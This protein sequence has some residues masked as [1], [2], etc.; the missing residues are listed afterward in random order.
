MEILETI[1]IGIAVTGILCPVLLMLALCSVSYTQV[2]E[3]L[4]QW[5]NQMGRQVSRK[6][7][8]SRFA[9][10]R[11]DRIQDYLEH[12]GVTYM[13]PG[14]A[15]PVSYLAVKGVFALL[16]MAAGL[17][18]HPAIGLLL[19]PVGFQAP[20]GLIRLSNQQDN[21]EMLADIKN[22]YDTLRIQT[23]AGVYLTHSLSECY[24]AVENGR[25]KAAL[26]TLTNRIVAKSD[27]T[28]ALEEFHEKFENK[29]IDILC[30]ILQQSLESGRTVQILEDVSSQLT[31]MQHAIHMKEK[32][33]LDRKIQVL[34]LLIFVG[35]MG[36]C[37]LG[38]GT[39]IMDSIIQF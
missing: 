2:G 1:R 21:D 8:T 32:E 22:V 3:R 17:Q 11:Y 12:Y 19:L 35:I 36:V 5:R 6:M 13:F 28:Q 27:I 38:L 16:C 9:Y 31:D 20:D 4:I 7:K 15:D 10:F 14:K 25:L 26:L 29:Y 24:L 18:I 34:Q 33:K 23:K 39:E 30:M 37:L